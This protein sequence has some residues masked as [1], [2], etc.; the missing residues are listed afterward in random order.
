MT[1]RENM[2]LVWDRKTPEWVPMI[3]IASQ[4]LIAPEINDRPLFQDGKDWF[5]LEWE[6]DRDNPNLM[7]HVVLEQNLCT[8]ISDW[9]EQIKFPSCRELPWEMIENRTKAMW[10]KKD[11]LMGY[12]VLNMGA[13]ERINAMMD[14]ENGLCAMYLNEDAYSE[15]VHAYADYR[16]EQMEY[17]KKY[18]D[19]DF[20]MMHD[21]WGNQ[22]SLFLSPEMWRK[23]YRD[24]EKRMADRCHEL[25]M[26]YMH[27]SCGVIDPIVDDMVEIGVD[28]W[29]S[30]SPENDCSAVKV[31]HGNNLIFAGGVDPLI[32][33]APGAT[34]EEIRAEVRRAIDV[35]GKDGGYLCS[36]AVMFSVVPGVDSIIEDEG[37]K[38]GRYE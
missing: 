24:P 36:S 12:V 1:E 15:Y 8:D 17:I 27:H 2:Q 11:E 14:F 18:L 6:L 9:K 10:Q 37:T 26:Y 23:F 32:T 29:H 21:D 4:M 30:V 5:G 13:F 3:G 16:I 7:T 33:D 22:K 31:K 20:L 28:S 35:L 25:G 38:Y 19:P 34:E